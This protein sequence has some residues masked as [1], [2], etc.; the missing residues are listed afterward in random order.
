MDPTKGAQSPKLA[1]AE[2]GMRHG[3]TRTSTIQLVC[4]S[5]GSLHFSFPIAPAR[6]GALL[7]GNAPRPQVSSSFASELGAPAGGVPEE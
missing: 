1:R 7:E 4:K 3:M 5:L 2:Q 6:K